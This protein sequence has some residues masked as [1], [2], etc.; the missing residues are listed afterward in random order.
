M[1]LFREMF[2]ELSAW[3]RFWLY[4]GLATL[5]CAA[6]MSFAFGVEIS[7][8]HA[9]FLA[10]L[11][12]IAAFLPEAAY[13]QWV[14]GRKIVAVVLAMVAVPTLL[15]EFYSHAGY[16]AG[17]RG[18]NIE[19]ALVQNTKYDARQDSVKESKT[20]LAMW[21]KRLADLESQNAWAAT[22]TAD[23]LRAQLASAN[24]AIDL[25]A[26]RGGCKTL[27]LARTKERDDISSKIAIAEE[28]GELTRKI[29]ATRRVVDGARDVAAK[30]EHKSSAVEHQ[31]KFLAKSVAMVSAGTLTPTEFMSEGS[32]QT[33]NLAMALAGT[34]L[35]AL[36]L[37]IAGLYRT[38]NHR[39]DQPTASAPVT[40]HTQ[41]GKPAPHIPTFALQRATVG[42]TNR[43]RVEA[44][45]AALPGRIE[46]RAA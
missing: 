16:T 38:R 18:S 22:V 10:C 25:E 3:G 24:L 8:K 45:L 11:T 9:L 26:K 42:E 40:H 23:A 37:F 13:S 4:L 15:I 30:T 39:D 5:V 33:V 44:L 41:D 35:P 32:Q 43:A 2:G 19:T 21:S 1:K 31:N 34:G 36:A 17:L 14:E 28:R 27:C 29:E 20:D 12:V 7:L 46:A 6:A